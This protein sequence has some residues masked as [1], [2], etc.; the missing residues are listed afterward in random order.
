MFM[1]G[2]LAYSELRSAREVMQSTSSEIIL[3]ST[4]FVSPKQYLSDLELLGQEE[5]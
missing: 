1:V 5:D 4:A 3:G 2:G